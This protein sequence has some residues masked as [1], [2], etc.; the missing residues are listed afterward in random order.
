MVHPGEVA[1]IAA[2]PDHLAAAGDFAQFRL[3][4]LDAVREADVRG[5]ALR[6]AERDRKGWIADMLVG[7]RHEHAVAK[8]RCAAPQE[9]IRFAA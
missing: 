5:R 3:A 8:G 4:E 1:R 6:A 7:E 2:A 9:N